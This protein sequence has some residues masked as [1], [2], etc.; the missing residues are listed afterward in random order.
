MTARQAVLD[1][2]GQLEHRT[3]RSA[4]TI[5]QVVDEVRSTTAAYRETTIRTYVTSVMCVDAP[6]HHANHTDDLVRV[7]RGVYRRIEAKDDLVDRRREADSRVKKRPQE[8]AETGDI[9]SECY[10]EGNLQ[11]AMV[12]HLAATGHAIRS[13]ANTA[14][15]ERGIDIVA[16]LDGRQVLVE[17]KGYPSRFYARGPKQG[18]VKKTHPSIQART[19]FADVLLSSLINAEDSPDSTIVICLPDV[20]TYRSLVDRTETAIGVLGICVAWVTEDGAVDWDGRF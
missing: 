2:F 12:A 16:I 14:T 4:F 13:V 8:Q 3:G 17:V 19:W 7:G 6:V 11:S 10:W 20:G 5:Q 9:Q 18:Q 15:K 1:A